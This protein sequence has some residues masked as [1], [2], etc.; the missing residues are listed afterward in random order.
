MPTIDGLYP[1]GGILEV[2]VSPGGNDQLTEIEFDAKGRTLVFQTTAELRLQ[3]RLFSDQSEGDAVDLTRSSKIFSGGNNRL[4]VQG[5]PNNEPKVWLSG[6]QN[7]LCTVIVFPAIA[8][9]GN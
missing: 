6:P 7:T 2:A 8:G 5:W 4:T 9:A 1:D 3:G